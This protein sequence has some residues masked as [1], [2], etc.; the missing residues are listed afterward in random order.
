MLP[1][2]YR[3]G[4]K[5][6][7]TS[8][9]QHLSQGPACEAHCRYKDWADVHTSTDRKTTQKAEEPCDRVSGCSARICTCFI[10]GRLQAGQHVLEASSIEEVPQLLHTSFG[11]RV[12]GSRVQG[13]PSHASQ[14]GY[15]TA[16]DFQSTGPRS[17]CVLSGWGREF[18]GLASFHQPLH[19]MWLKPPLHRLCNAGGRKEI[20]GKQDY[21]RHEESA[22]RL[23]LIMRPSR[24]LSWAVA[25]P[26]L[27]SHREAPCHA[28]RRT[29][30]NTRNSATKASG[31]PPWETRPSISSV[32]T[33]SSGPAFLCSLF[34]AQPA[35]SRPVTLVSPW[36]LTFS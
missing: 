34:C 32:A 29:W 23:S 18:A 26:L 28:A 16:S 10:Q 27:V 21:P 36:V 13:L 9:V 31:K 3:E 7:C 2:L 12:C 1:N 25:A 35:C 19:C 30:V 15:F 22:T 33:R 24:P 8:P 5:P 11:F 20:K 14:P 17:K 6:S 4:P